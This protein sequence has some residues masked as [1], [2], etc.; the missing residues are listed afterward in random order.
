MMLIYI[1]Y[2]FKNRWYIEI[3]V[4]KIKYIN[5]I[6]LNC[7]IKIGYLI[8]YLIYKINVVIKIGGKELFFLSFNFMLNIMGDIYL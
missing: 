5:I 3:V 6:N 2:N 1:C 4:V 8:W 7:E